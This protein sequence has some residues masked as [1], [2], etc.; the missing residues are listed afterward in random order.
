MERGRDA[1]H[2]PEEQ[3]PVVGL[4]A[5]RTTPHASAG[6]EVSKASPVNASRAGGGVRKEA[7][8]AAARAVRHKCEVERCGGG[9][10][11]PQPCRNRT[12]SSKCWWAGGDGQ[13]VWRRIGSRCWPLAVWRV[14]RG[15]TRV[16]AGRRA[17][18]GGAGERAMSD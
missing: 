13:L 9:G 18:G 4:G 1:W 7:V 16:G 11:S 5:G 3:S 17:H 10:H 12:K 6:R 2:S 8:G 15:G 14:A